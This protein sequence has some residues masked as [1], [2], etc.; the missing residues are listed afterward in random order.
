MCHLLELGLIELGSSDPASTLVERLIESPHVLLQVIEYIFSTERLDLLK[1]C[2][3]MILRTC[4]KL[5][6]A[7]S[8]EAPHMHYEALRDAVRRW[9]ANLVH[10]SD[11]PALQLANGTSIPVWLFPFLWRPS[12]STMRFARGESRRAGVAMWER[13]DD[14]WAGIQ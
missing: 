8:T 11:S 3:G 1:S 2:T 9:G 4:L 6:A 14:T 7:A 10:G 5:D 13:I 12:V